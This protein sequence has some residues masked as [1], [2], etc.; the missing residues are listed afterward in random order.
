MSEHKSEIGRRLRVNELKERT[1]VV[2]RR[3]DSRSALTM[4]IERISPTGVVFL[5]GGVEPPIHFL[6]VRL[7]QDLALIDDTGR[8]IIVYEYLG[9]I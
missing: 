2:I 3:A 6:A 8:E 1:V 4:W 5:A 9:A 7:P